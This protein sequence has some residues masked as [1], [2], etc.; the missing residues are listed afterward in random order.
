MAAE[1]ISTIERRRHWPDEEKLRI[2]SEA[3][4][5]GSTVAAV[6]DRNGV[7][8]SLVYLWLRLARSSRLPGISLSD[9]PATSFVP[10]RIEPPQRPALAEG[11]PA[12]QVARPAG[13]RRRTSMVEVTLGNGRSLKVDESI[14]PGALARLV[15]ALDGGG[16]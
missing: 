14:D 9:P 4:A 7:C 15:A 2:M 10:V 16:S 11:P 8:R 1:I 12:T 6:A 5:P 13:A 3:L